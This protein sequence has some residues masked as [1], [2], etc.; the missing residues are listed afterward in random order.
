MLL[1]LL[2]WCLCKAS[3]DADEYINNLL[4]KKEEK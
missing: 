2:V 1:L 3:A 4:L